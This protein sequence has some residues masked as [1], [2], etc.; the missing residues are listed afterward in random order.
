MALV[1]RLFFDQLRWFSIDRLERQL[2]DYVERTLSLFWQRQIMFLLSIILTVFYFDFI[3]TLFCY[4][5]ILL[6]EVL[7]VLIAKRINEWTDL[8]LSAANK[9]LALIVVNTIFSAAAI[10]FWV[11]LLAQQQGVGGHFMPLFFLFSASLF[12]SMNNHQLLPAL[13][14]RLIIYGSTFL[15]IPLHDIWLVRP[16]LGSELWLN[17]FTVIFVLYFIIDSSVSFLRLYRNGVRQLE[18]L[19][20]EYEK[21]KAAHDAKSEFLATVSHELRTPLTAIKGVLDLANFGALGQV[22]KKMNRALEIAGKNSNH[23]AYL[24]N[25]LLDLQKMETDEMVFR[26]DKLNV[27]QLILDAVD[28]TNALADSPQ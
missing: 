28:A 15:F 3:K 8:S 7:D 11:I 25:D 9:F 1:K 27:G 19:S 14:L 6:T 22:P 4:A 21:V 16:D 5:L 17:F 10:G 23:L 24:I 20:R 12:A 2:K 18:E 13:T 26:F